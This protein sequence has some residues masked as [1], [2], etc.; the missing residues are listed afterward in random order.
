MVCLGFVRIWSTISNLIPSGKGSF[1]KAHKDTPR[2]E[3]MFGS[4][5]V[6]FP[7]VH[8]GGSLILR[9]RGKEWNF[10]SAKEVVEQSN[11]SIGYIAFYS[12][13]EHEVT[14]VTSGYRVTLTYNL[15]FASKKGSKPYL[16]ASPVEIAFT[17]TL[18]A[19]LDDPEFLP[20]GGNIGF[21]LHHQYPTK[22]CL[23]PLKG[24]LKGVD[25]VVEKVC[26]K[27]S[28]KVYL[29]AAYTGYDGDDD[30]QL[31]LSGGVPDLEGMDEYVN[32]LSVVKEQGGKVVVRGGEGPARSGEIE[33]WWIKDVKPKKA[34]RF[35]SVY[36]AY[37]NEASI[38][39]LYGDCCLVILVGPA[40][41]RSTL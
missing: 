21:A 18:R 5:V 32:P 12:D 10:D 40:G 34:R 24:N 3:R 27:L 11:P 19:L 22:D 36:L 14:V 41:D 33:I 23:Y 31:V 4:L 20:E 8:E 30:D 26:E 38:E 9:H 25:A 1:F 7:T 29:Q 16:A 28:L 2:G 17:S 13:V 39:Y 6:V 15:Y 37:G 35:E